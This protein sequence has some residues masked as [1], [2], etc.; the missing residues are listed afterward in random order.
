MCYVSRINIYIYVIL[1]IIKRV[2]VENASKLYQFEFIFYKVQMVKNIS[3]KII[4]GVRFDFKKTLFKNIQFGILLCPLIIGLTN[5]MGVNPKLMT[6]ISLIPLS[7]TTYNQTKKTMNS[8]N[9]NEYRTHQKKEEELEEDDEDEEIIAY[10][11]IIAAKAEEARKEEAKQKNELILKAIEVEIE[12]RKELPTI[13]EY[14]YKE[15]YNKVK[16]HH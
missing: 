11:A 1:D 6:L 9:L 7:T 3:K 8:E 2:L 16:I 12:S 14:A 10:E 4:T 15:I 5:R 13:Y